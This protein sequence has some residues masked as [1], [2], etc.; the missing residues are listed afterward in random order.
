MQF[1]FFK[2]VIVFFHLTIVQLVLVTL[3]ICSQ[4]AEI[5]YFLYE[6]EGIIYYVT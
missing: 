4:A 1:N 2:K 3:F 6:P 5:D